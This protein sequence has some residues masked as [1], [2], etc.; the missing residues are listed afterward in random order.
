M[1]DAVIETVHFKKPA[2]HYKRDTRVIHNAIDQQAFYLAR[3]K[4]ISVEDAKAFIMKHLGKGGRFEFHDPEVTYMHRENYEDRVMKK[5]TMSRYLKDVEEN[6]ES[7]SPTFTSYCSPDVRQSLLALNTMEKIKD[8]DRI[9][10]EMFDAQNAGDTVTELFKNIGQNNAKIRNNSLSGASLSASTCLFNP[11][12]HSSLTTNCRNTTAYGNANNEKF[13]EGNRHYFDVE[14]ILNNLVSISYLSDMEKVERA[15]KEY[16]LHY[17]T[18]E[19]V[20][21]CIDRSRHLYFRSDQYMKEVYDYIDKMKP[22]ERAAFVYTSDFYHLYKHNKA[23]VTGFLTRVIQ[24][25]TVVLHNP[26]PMMK[27]VD[28]DVINLARQICRN[29]SAGKKPKEIRKESE[30]NYQLLARTVWNINESLISIKYIVDAFW[31]S[32][33]MPAS[34]GNFPW[35]LR[36]S[37]LGGD[38]DSTLFT[39]QEWVQRLFG[40][41]GF[42]DDENST[43]DVIIF[44]AAQ[45]V[46]H[47]LAKMSGN[48]GVH[49][50]RVFD[51]QMKNEYKFD[52][53]TPTTMAKHYFA[54]QSAQEGNVY[55]KPKLEMKG[56]NFISSATPGDVVKDVKE[57]IMKLMMDVVA[58]ND[59][60]LQDLLDQ[61]KA[62]EDSIYKTVKSGDT[63]FFRA[64][65]MKA[66]KAYKIEDPDK[67]PYWNHTFWN[68]TFGKKYGMADEPPYR[69]LKVAMGIRNISEFND[70]MEKLD[71]GLAEDIRTEL[72]RVGKK[73][74]TTGY[75][76][77]PIVQLTGIP[78]EFLEAANARKIVKDSCSVYYHFLESMG[79]M[80]VNGKNTRMVYDLHGK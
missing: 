35:S 23:F 53:F 37:V 21:E 74:I 76:P 46:Q 25:P 48:Y 14:V 36:R 27:A 33:N 41:I 9:K 16:G 77:M 29:F 10:G 65:D 47:L 45:T 18:K 50:D 38:T 63:Q 70:W 42:S 26:D 13:I 20:I 40:K 49:P 57:M 22:L 60:Y 52:I 64:I 68:R 1:T 3:M 19:D 51:I 67:N 61:I 12:S 59:I 55:R 58:G 71:A 28:E 5:T 44:L 11:T 34:A 56:A 69:M 31:M 72:A 73:F 79:I 6:N 15:M 2:E 30:E 66:A 43:S 17:P 62:K 78:D 32:D 8:R 39:A 7:M 75:I 54:M 4:G 80:M 24:K